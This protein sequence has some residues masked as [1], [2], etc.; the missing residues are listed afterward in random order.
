M[1][2][3]SRLVVID[4]A[5][6]LTGPVRDRAAAVLRDAPPSAIVVSATDAGAARALLIEARRVNVGILDLDSSRSALTSEVTS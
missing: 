5:D 2:G 6:V 4:G 1:R 3:S